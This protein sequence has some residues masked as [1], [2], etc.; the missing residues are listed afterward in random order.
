[1]T[2]QPPA[3]FATVPSHPLG[4]RKTTSVPRAGRPIPATLREVL[5]VT[6]GVTALDFETANQARWSVCEVG[7]ADPTGRTWD[8]LVDPGGHFAD[9][10]VGIHGIRAADVAGAPELD[11][12]ADLLVLL[13]GLTVVAHNVGFERSVVTKVFERVGRRA[14]AVQWLCTLDAARAKL[15]HLPNHRLPTVAR[16]LDVP[17]GRH[18][19]AAD[20]AAAAMG[21]AQRLA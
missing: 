15:P 17:M 8:T 1:M 21:I 12:L 19:T 3:T 11:E 18:H 16:A 10:N 9:V 20:D 2:R 13:D 5:D 14:P 7:L 4:S 6:A